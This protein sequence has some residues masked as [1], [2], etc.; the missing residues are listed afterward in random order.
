MADVIRILVVDDS[1]LD[2]TALASPLDAS[3]FEVE[4]AADGDQALEL[5]STFNPDVILLDMFMPGMH[6][7]ELI[8]ELRAGECGARI[9]VV[10]GDEQVA[11]REQ[12]KVLD[13][14]DFFVKP[15]NV[16]TLAQRVAALVGH[17]S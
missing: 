8:R 5:A 1:R 16:S 6:G 13:V 12:C 11:V 15:V 14:A 4:E 7:A 3:G 9:I 10:T 17:S 2:R